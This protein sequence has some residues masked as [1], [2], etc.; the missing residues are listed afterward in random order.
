MTSTVWRSERLVSVSEAGDATSA[1]PAGL[2]ASTPSR[3]RILS[4]ELDGEAP[5]ITNVVFLVGLLWYLWMS[6]G[7]GVPPFEFVFV[8][9]VLFVAGV[10]WVLRFGWMIV[11]LRSRTTRS[12][13]AWFVVPLLV[14]STVLADRSHV[15]LEM[16]FDLARSDFD[17]MVDRAM[18]D[19][20]FE[21]TDITVRSFAVDRIYRD[22]AIVVF[23]TAEGGG[24]FGVAGFAYDPAGRHQFVQDCCLQQY[25][26]LG[27]HWYAWM[28]SY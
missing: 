14:I 25:T 9:C 4:R 3:R 11:H 26:A 24:F 16:R 1:A 28:I 10:F 18:T 13:W 21:R 5:R 19:E 7:P 20:E 23:E 6:S 17:Q 2:S 15:A 27:G 22:G 8:A 12:P